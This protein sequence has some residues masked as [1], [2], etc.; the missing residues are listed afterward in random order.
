MKK[1]LVLLVLLLVG[2]GNEEIIEEPNVPS[3]VVESEISI[4]DLDSNTRPYIVVVNNFPSAV[5][6]QTGLQDAY[7]VYEIPVEG[8]MTRLLALYKDKT[9]TKIGTVRS[10]RHNFLDYALENDA[11]FVHFGWSHYAQSDIS[12]LGI[13]SI[14]GLYDAPFW[15]ENKENLAT[16]HTAFTSL[17]KVINTVKN[18]NYKLTTEKE[19]LLNYSTKKVDLS[20]KEDS[21]TANE[22]I[23]P[24]S[25]SLNT[26]YRYDDVN[27]N[28][29]RYVNGNANTD[30]ETKEQYTTKNIIVVKVDFKYASDGYYLDIHNI[31]SGNGYYITNGYAVPITWEKKDRSSQTIYKY[32]DG[33]EIDVNDG[34]TYIQFQS[35][36]QELTIK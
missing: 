4:I 26:T 5:K 9:S 34:N 27:K 30:Y 36:N 31:G 24:S 35:N 17:D 28:Y 14:N 12:S 25:K 20:E 19:T 22:I 33:T 8:G 21:I 18:K 6:V 3:P 15:R 10:A 23:I 13:N 29:K 2:C 1:L 16:E 7:I 32:I 11:I